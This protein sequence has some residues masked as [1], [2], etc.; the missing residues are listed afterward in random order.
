MRFI[1]FLS[2]K[3]RPMDGQPTFCRSLRWLAPAILLCCSALSACRKP[4]GDAALDTTPAP[5]KRV[6]ASTPASSANPAEDLAQEVGTLIAEFA[7]AGTDEARRVEII[8]ELAVNS[9]PAAR[10]T[11]DRIYRT[12]PG[13]EL[14]M[15]VIESLQLIDSDDLEPSLRLLQDAVAVG[16]DADLREAAV[17]TLRDLDSPKTI[18]LWRSLL[19]DRDEEIR[20]TARN[21]IEFLGGEAKGR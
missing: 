14:K 16:Q 2:R 13:I 3:T 5:R 21:M 4:A 18:R 7:D 8:G 11:L 17:E 19:G 15:Q 1:P 6:A 10:E 20:D 9:T 12:A